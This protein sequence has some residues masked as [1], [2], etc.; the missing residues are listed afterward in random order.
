[1]SA[2][3]WACI[4]HPVMFLWIFY[5]KLQSQF[6]FLLQSSICEC[7]RFFLWFYAAQGNWKKSP[8]AVEELAH[9]FTVSAVASH[10]GAEQANNRSSEG[11]GNSREGRHRLNSYTWKNT[12][13][14]LASEFATAKNIC[15]WSILKRIRE[16]R[17]KRS[18]LLIL[19]TGGDSAKIVLDLSSGRLSF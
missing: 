6:Y 1:M 5:Q 15:E 12:F 13:L 4:F 18:I 7:L 2:G 14:S 10:A 9:G 16:K 19:Q 8:F 17:L 11:L 3:V